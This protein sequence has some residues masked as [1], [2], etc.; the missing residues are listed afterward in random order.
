MVERVE[1]GGLMSFNYSKG[2]SKK[3][4]KSERK[5]IEGAYEKYYE[6]KAEEKKKKRI[7]WGAVIIL[8][9][10]ILVFSLFFRG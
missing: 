1:T 2:E 3:L 5:E 9:I 7:V 4:G 10:L 6:R 8:L